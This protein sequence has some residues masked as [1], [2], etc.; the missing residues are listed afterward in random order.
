MGAIPFI[1]FHSFNFGEP[2]KFFETEIS[3][4]KIGRCEVSILRDL[5]MSYS[6][7]DFFLNV[8]PEEL[9]PALRRYNVNPADM[10]SP[11]VVLLLQYDDRKVLIDTGIGFAE[12]PVMVGEHP[13]EKKGR[14]QHLLASENIKKEDITDVILSHFHPDHIGGI[15][16]VDKTLVFPNARYHAPKEEWDFWHSSKADNQSPFFKFFIA[17]QVTPL[18]D[19]DLNLFT[20]D[21]AEILPGVFAVQAFGHTP[22]HVAVDI[23]FEKEHLLY[24]SDAFIHPL[25][26]ENL[27]WQTKYDNDHTGARKS[28]EKILDLAYRENM[29][30]NA[31]HFDFPGLGKVEKEG[32]NWRWKKVG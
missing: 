21:Y 12:K 31:F 25:H 28:R 22:G 10:P 20:G 16:N 15:F 14:L 23:N 32:K 6:S 9:D 1:N 18:K 19:K 24:A 8:K 27:H 3:R 2:L 4:L 11:F 29:L 7:E 26:I 5:I 13:L 30:V 17:D